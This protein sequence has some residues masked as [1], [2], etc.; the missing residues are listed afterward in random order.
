MQTGKCDL[1]GRDIAGAHL[2]HSAAKGGNGAIMQKLLDL[3][4]DETAV[5]S[6][7]RTCLHYAATGEASNPSSSCM[8]IEQCACPSCF[9][10][11]AERGG[12]SLS[13]KG[14]R[15]R[16]ARGDDRMAAEARCGAEPQGWHRSHPSDGCHRDWL[17][18][19]GVPASRA[20]RRPACMQR[21]W[22]HTPALCIL[23]R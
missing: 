17:P 8:E 21:C 15:G 12:W 20:R 7:G 1:S 5:T 9:V 18:G 2:V 6:S 4:A 11:Q 13:E 14:L 19:T 10:V 3:G 16:R 22:L 23:L